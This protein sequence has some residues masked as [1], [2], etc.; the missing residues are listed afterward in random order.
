MNR[1]SRYWKRTKQL[2]MAIQRVRDLH[3]PHGVYCMY[4]VTQYPCR[5]IK[6]LDGV[7]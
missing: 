6:A 4:C 3:K 1:A 2:E 5:T 7:E